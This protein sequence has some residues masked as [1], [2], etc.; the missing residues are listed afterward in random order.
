[1]M[2]QINLPVMSNFMAHICNASNQ[3]SD[4]HQAFKTQATQLFSVIYC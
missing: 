2:S 4:P 3:H 1:M